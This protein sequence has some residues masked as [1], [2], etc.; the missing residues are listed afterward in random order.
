MTEK[1]LELVRGL[2]PWA[3]AAIVVGTM[4]GTGIFLKPAEMAREGHSVSVVYA[5]WIVGASPLPLRRAFLRGARCGHSRSGW[6]VRLPSAR[7]RH[8][9][10]ISFWMDA[11]HRWSSILRRIH[12]RRHDALSQFLCS[13]RGHSA[14]SR[15]TSL[16]P[17]S[18]IGF[19]LTI[20]FS[21]GRNRSPFSG[22]SP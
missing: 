6:R 19:I 8:R 14:F 22:S 13:R 17:A 18:P 1:R 2:G 21:P 5:A 11:L 20:L 3:S 12:R 16:F 15:G 9:L 10:G 7:V 4:I